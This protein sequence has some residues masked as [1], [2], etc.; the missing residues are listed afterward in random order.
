MCLFIRKFIGDKFG[1]TAA[2]NVRILYGGSVKPDNTKGLMSQAD[3]DG[4]LIGGASLDVESFLGIVKNTIDV[5][6]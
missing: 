3:V 4:A 6:L 1:F 2:Q 5:L